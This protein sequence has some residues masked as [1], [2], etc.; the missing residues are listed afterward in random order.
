MQPM[1]ELYLE[2]RAIPALRQLL[3]RKRLAAVTAMKRQRHIMTSF[4]M[5]QIPISCPQGMSMERK[6][7]PD[8]LKYRQR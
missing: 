5:A 6:N 8:S 7:P 2:Q 1:A 4:S 3:Q